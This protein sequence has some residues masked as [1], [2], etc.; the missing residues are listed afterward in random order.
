[1][2]IFKLCVYENKFVKIHKEKF[3]FDIVKIC[4]YQTFKCEMITR[5]YHRI[6][7]QRCKSEN[8][9]QEKLN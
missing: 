2:K 6:K 4:L 9:N 1:M 8:V 5:G 3:I 7:V